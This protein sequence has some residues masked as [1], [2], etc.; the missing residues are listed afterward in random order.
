VSAPERLLRT[1]DVADWLDVQPATVLRW[2]ADRGLPGFRIASNAL[3][4]RAEEVEAW[5]RSTREG[6]SASTHL[7]A[8]DDDGPGGPEEE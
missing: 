7:A 4:F 3:R 8:V 1:Q 5:L 2:H 6:T